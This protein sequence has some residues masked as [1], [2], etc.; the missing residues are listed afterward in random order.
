VN[1]V[2]SGDV[3]LGANLVHHV[4]DSN[5]VLR[6]KCGDSNW[7]AEVRS[8]LPCMQGVSPSFSDPVC[9]PNSCGDYLGG[10][11]TLSSAPDPF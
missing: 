2:W 7:M 10:S 4:V 6:G 3:G 8:Q 5:L 11:E 1:G 9:I